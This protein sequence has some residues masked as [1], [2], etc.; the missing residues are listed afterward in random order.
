MALA[1]TEQRGVVVLQVRVQPRSSRDAVGG[2]WNGALR[3]RLTAPPAD[4]R[5]NEAC[6]RLLAEQ[7]NIPL[8]AVRI[9][10]GERSRTK[11]IAL[12]GV[13]AEQVARLAVPGA[14][15]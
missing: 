5:A 9:L 8:S 2:E 4:G 3:I 11:R 7:L 6:R 15:R 1:L 12:D 14:H 10:A 13:T